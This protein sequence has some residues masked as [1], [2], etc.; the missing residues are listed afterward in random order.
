MKLVVDTNILMS[1][2]MSPSGRVADGDINHLVEA[3]LFCPHFLVVELFDKKERILRYTKLP[4]ADVSELYYQLLK[5]I[6]FISE[7][8]ISNE[9]LKAAYDLVLGIDL[10]DLPF[11]ALALHINA[12]LW[13]G[14]RALINALRIKDFPLLLTTAELGLD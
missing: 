8:L 2:L 14:D 11:V 3:E 6:T 12:P 9:T 1:A 10:K 5:R 4:T 13:T 7:D